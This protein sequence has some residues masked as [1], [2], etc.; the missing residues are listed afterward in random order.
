MRTCPICQATCFDDMET[1]FGCMHRFEAGDDEVEMPPQAALN[2]SVAV[3]MQSDC[4]ETSGDPVH[5]SSFVQEE[6]TAPL[7]MHKE[8]VLQEGVS[9]DAAF[10]ASAGD[11]S[12][13]NE[14]QSMRMPFGG[15]PYQIVISLQPIR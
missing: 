11:P 3:P 7:D 4:T 12:V 10:P 8:G 2:S 9:P 5:R 1:C 6:K 13:W 14:R 15:M